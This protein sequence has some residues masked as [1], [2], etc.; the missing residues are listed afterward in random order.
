MVI[1]ISAIFEEEMLLDHKE[2]LCSAKISYT[3]ILVMHFRLEIYLIK[4][5]ICLMV[6]GKSE[7]YPSICRS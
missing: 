5:R 6:N 7:K 1:L 4:G 2:H 3:I